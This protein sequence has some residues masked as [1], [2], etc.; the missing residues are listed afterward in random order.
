MISSPIVT[1]NLW[2]DG[3]VMT[4]P[5]LG[6]VDAPV[7][8]IFDKGAIVGERAEA[9]TGAAV[10][11]SSPKEKITSGQGVSPK[12]GMAGQ[13]WPSSQPSTG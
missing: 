12:L 9:G 8:W 4:T 3:P 2:L 10:N 1:V 11:S 13:R 6:L 7:H 5:F